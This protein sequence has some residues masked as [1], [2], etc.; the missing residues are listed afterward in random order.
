LSN[1]ALLLKKYKNSI[2]IHEYI[3]MNQPRRMYINAN[4]RINTQGEKNFD[5]REGT[6]ETLD[7]FIFYIYI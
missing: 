2:K 6:T 4:A 1:K 7:N 5:L 3:F